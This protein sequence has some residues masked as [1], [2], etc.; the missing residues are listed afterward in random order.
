MTDLVLAGFLDRQRGSPKDVSKGVSV[1]GATLTQREREV[2]QLIAEGRSNKEVA[3]ALGIGVK[4]VE[5]HRAN[6]MTKLD[7][8]S[9]AD[10]VRYAIRNGIIVA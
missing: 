1:G 5:T 9:V 4:T 2:L 3:T 8:H 10:L 6:L 7:L